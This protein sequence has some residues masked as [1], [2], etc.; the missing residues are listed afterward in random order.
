MKMDKNISRIKTLLENLN[1]KDCKL[2]NQ[3][4]E[5]RKFE[6]LKDLIE[7]NIREVKTKL[8]DI[9]R[10]EINYSDKLDALMKL[11]DI[12]NQYYPNIEYQSSYPEDPYLYDNISN[13]T[14]DYEIGDI[15]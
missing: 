7:S 5:K 9:R 15:Y 10:L 4:L 1:S 6:D 2:G 8:L 13:Y 11:E 3:L 12:L 14:D